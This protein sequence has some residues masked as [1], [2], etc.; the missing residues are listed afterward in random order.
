MKPAVRI[1]MKNLQSS[2]AMRKERFPLCFGEKKE[3]DAWLEHEGIA[4]T[5]LFRK[6]ICE[7]CTVSH[8]KNMTTIG[9]CVNSQV[10]LK[11]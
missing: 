9:R 1:A 4:H 6:N 3:Y 2:L 5:S 10:I 8:Q 7:D 11:A